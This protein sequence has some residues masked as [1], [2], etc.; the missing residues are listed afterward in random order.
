MIHPTGLEDMLMQETTRRGSVRRTLAIA[1][2]GAIVSIS[3]LASWMFVNRTGGLEKPAASMLLE[4]L[5]VFMVTCG[6]LWIA[7]AVV[8]LIPIRGFPRVGR[9]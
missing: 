4:F 3:L 8:G 6:G 1:T 7:A 5:T 9:R 2:V